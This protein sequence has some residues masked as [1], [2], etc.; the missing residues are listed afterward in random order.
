M[1]A[2]QQPHFLDFLSPSL[3]HCSP[4]LTFIEFMYLFYSVPCSRISVNSVNIAIEWGTPLAHTTVEAEK[5]EN[6]TPCPI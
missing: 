3:I 5:N 6:S 1:Q 2:V 4:K